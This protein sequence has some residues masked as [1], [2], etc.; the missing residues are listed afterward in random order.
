MFRLTIIACLVILAAC[1]QVSTAQSRAAKVS[2][3]EIEGDRTERIASVSAII[4]EHTAPP[5]AILDANFLQQQLGDGNFGPSDYW[6]F[7][8][9]EVAPKDIAQWTQLL[10]PLTTTPNYNAP[11]QAPAQPVD[12]WIASDDFTALQF[13]EPSVLSGRAHG[14]VGVSAQTGHI[15]IF[16]FTM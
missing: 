7:Y 12:W 2:V 6:A 10:T 16:T 14:W 11:D 15:Y 4:G 8:S 5:T 13:Y 3:Y 9:I 1:G